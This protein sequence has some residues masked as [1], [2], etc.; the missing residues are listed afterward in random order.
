M[1]NRIRL[2]ILLLVMC[3]LLCITGCHDNPIV[4]ITTQPSVQETTPSVTIAPLEPADIYT[5]AVAALGSN[6]GMELKMTQAMTVAGRSFT[7]SCTQTIQFWNLDGDN[8]LVKAEDTTDYGD[9]E[10]TRA[11][12]F[13]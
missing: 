4:P 1:R 12:Y 9:Y 8:F 3:L 11:E 6:V 5:D 13:S 2:S 7:S 10:Y